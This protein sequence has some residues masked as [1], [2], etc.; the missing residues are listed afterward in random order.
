MELL[1]LWGK[2]NLVY[3]MADFG[4]CGRIALGSEQVRGTI[5][6]SDRNA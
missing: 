5:K 1:G 3:L 4:V 6:S 2:K